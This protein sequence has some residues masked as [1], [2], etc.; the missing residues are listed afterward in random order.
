MCIR[1][2]IYIFIFIAVPEELFF[3]AWVQNLLERR[4][5]RR[6]AL[7]IT[8]VL[9]GLSHFNKRS[10]HFNWRYVLLASIAGIFYGRAWR[11]QRRVPASAI[12]H[13]SVDAIW[14]FWF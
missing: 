1:D 13:A 9:F 5:G 4:V 2:R 3:R 12:T 6:A 10:A 11:E 8:A 7:A 14:S